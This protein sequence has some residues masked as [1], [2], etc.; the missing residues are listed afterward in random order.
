MY[1]QY[2]Y[3]YMLNTPPTH[4]YACSFS[5]HTYTRCLSPIHTP[6]GCTQLYSRHC[7][8]LQSC[9]GDAGGRTGPPGQGLVSPWSPTAP[10]PKTWGA[11]KVPDGFSPP[12][13]AQPG[14][15]P[16]RPTDDLNPQLQGED[17]RLPL[18]AFLILELRRHMPS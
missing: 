14:A 3:K 13:P 12:S 6:Y 1:A 18:I 16:S 7:A 4:V 17:L 5:V 15:L 9:A 11:K 10:N 2:M 8:T